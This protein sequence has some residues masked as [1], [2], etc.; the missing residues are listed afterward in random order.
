MSILF[1]VGNN[2]I[3]EI[4]VENKADVNAMDNDGQTPL[5]AAAWEGMLNDFSPK[6]T[7][8]LK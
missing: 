7:E 4:L 5:F 6:R 1:H 8:L 2:K 3:V